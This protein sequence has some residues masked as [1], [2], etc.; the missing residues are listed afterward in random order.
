MQLKIH[1]GY[2]KT[3]SLADTELIGKTFEEGIRQHSRRP[4]R[5]SSAFQGTEQTPQGLFLYL[6]Q[7]DRRW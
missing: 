3:I 7:T 2:R 6:L 4:A 1:K 5:R